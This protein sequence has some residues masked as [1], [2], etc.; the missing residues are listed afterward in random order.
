M[1]LSLEE[2]TKKGN[3]YVKGLCVPV[4]PSFAVTEVCRYSC[5]TEQSLKQ[6]KHKHVEACILQYLSDSHYSAHVSLNIALI[7]YISSVWFEDTY[8]H[9]ALKGRNILFSDVC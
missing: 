6:I 9:E 3:L 1:K 5:K 2:D 4:S 8:V 7:Q